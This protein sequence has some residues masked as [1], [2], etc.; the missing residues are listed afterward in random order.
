[1]SLR[2]RLLLRVAA[3]L[4]IGLTLL[5]VLVHLLLQAAL[6]REVDDLLRSR[7]A[8]VADELRSG[9]LGTSARIG[10]RPGG[11]SGGPDELSSPGL[12]VQIASADGNVLARSTNLGG[13]TLPLP[14]EALGQGPTEEGDFRTVP[15][16]S[17][18]RVRVH[19]V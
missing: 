11:I 16:A 8:V 12:Y 17:N 15:L 9:A 1:M 3:V 19:V 4:G 14:T 6:T 18:E 7:A 2:T 5:G 10:D 13:A